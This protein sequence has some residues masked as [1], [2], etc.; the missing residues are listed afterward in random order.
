MAG[1]GFTFICGWNS[2]LLAEGRNQPCIYVLLTNDMTTMREQILNNFSRFPITLRRLIRCPNLLPFIDPLTQNG[3]DWFLEG[4][5]GFV[6]RNRQEA[7]GLPGKDF[8]CLG[9]GHIFPL[10]ADTSHRQ[11]YNFVA[12]Q[13]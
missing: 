4:G 7:H 13:S 12:T 5:S 10:P 2:C 11:A 8:S 1:N 3:I 6:D 9:H